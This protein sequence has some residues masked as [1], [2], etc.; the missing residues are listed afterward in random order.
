[1]CGGG[2]DGRTTTL[3]FSNSFGPRNFCGLVPMLLATC[4]NSSYGCPLGYKGKKG[5]GS[6]ECGM[7]LRPN[8]KGKPIANICLFTNINLKNF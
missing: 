2:N 7:R 1:M 5:C 8:G 6:V 4:N 3:F